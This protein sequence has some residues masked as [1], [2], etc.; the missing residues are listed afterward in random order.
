MKFEVHEGKR[1]RLVWLP[2]DNQRTY[3]PDCLRSRDRRQSRAR[4]NELTVP[5]SKTALVVET[6][7]MARPTLLNELVDRNLL[8]IYYM[9]GRSSCW[10]NVCRR[11]CRWRVDYCEQWMWPQM[12]AEAVWTYG[13]NALAKTTN[14]PYVDHSTIQFLVYISRDAMW[15][16]DLKQLTSTCLV[17]AT[18]VERGWVSSAL[19]L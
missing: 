19:L 5:S 18:A 9:A 14:T 2:G 7:E 8:K 15:I 11:F 13:L 17:S 3:S 1:V 6:F 16:L 4:V 12:G 10:V